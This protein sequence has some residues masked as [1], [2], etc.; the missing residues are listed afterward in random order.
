MEDTKK[1]KINYAVRRKV[2][3]LFTDILYRNRYGFE[4]EDQMDKIAKEVEDI[5]SNGKYQ[6]D[7]YGEEPDGNL[8][9][10]LKDKDCQA[11]LHKL[12]Q[13]FLAVEPRHWLNNLIE[14]HLN[15]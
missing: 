13:D 6:K 5:C 10:A 15:D 8:K 9:E 11:F 2:E 1:F 4:S 14:V 7:Y 12:L 3:F